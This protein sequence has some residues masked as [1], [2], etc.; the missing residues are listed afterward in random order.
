[1]SGLVSKRSARA[2]DLQSDPTN[3]LVVLS[4]QGEVCVSG[5]LE[6]PTAPERLKMTR[7]KSYLAKSLT[8]ETL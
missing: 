6:A 1:M 8:L 3:A 4:E 5:N 2:L 7:K